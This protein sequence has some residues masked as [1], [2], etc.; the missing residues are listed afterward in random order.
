MIFYINISERTDKYLSISFKRHQ[1]HSKDVLGY[2]VSLFS[3]EALGHAY[4]CDLRLLV[5]FEY[6]ET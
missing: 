5:F 6:F 2:L 1:Y 4:I 3:I